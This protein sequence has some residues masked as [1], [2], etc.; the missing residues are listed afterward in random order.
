MA[1]SIASTDS[2]DGTRT[3]T[4]PLTTD[5]SAARGAAANRAIRVIVADGTRMGSQLIADALKTDLRFDVAGVCAASDEVLERAAAVQPDVVIIN[6]NLDDQ[7]LKGFEVAKQLRTVHSGTK[8][9]VLLDS[10]KRDLVIRAFGSGAR[11]IFCRAQSI[12]A[13]RKCICI[14]HAGQVWASSEELR[15]VLETF[16]ESAPTRLVDSRGAVLLSKR[17]QDVVRCVTEGLT[18]REI[19]QRLKLSEHTVKNYIFRIFDKLGVSTRVEVV[20]Y[21][22]SQR[23][24]AGAGSPPLSEV[25]RTRKAAEEGVGPAQLKLA[26]MYRE[27]QGVGRDQLAS[28]MWFLV[29]DSMGRELCARAHA[30]L[31]AASGELSRG[32]IE[33]AGRMATEWLDQ[34]GYRLSL[35]ARGAKAAD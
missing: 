7:P 19:A 16:A 5:H 3:S 26:E 34:H 12:E 4:R 28:Y 29:A 22:F 31:D 17:E 24:A 23:G 30:A 14:V 8:V 32:E 35:P 6:V 2:S 18:N 10:P 20:L 15:I 11:G 13:L 9:I 25:E 1:Y 33:A 21:A 27:G